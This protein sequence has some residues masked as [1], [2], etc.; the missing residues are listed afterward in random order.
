MPGPVPTPASRE[1]KPMARYKSSRV[2]ADKA[3]PFSSML[4]ASEATGIR[5]GMRP[6]AAFNNVVLPLPAAPLT[7][8]RCPSSKLSRTSA[9]TWS[10]PPKP[11][12]R[13]ESLSMRKL[14]LAVRSESLEAGRM[15][16]LENLQGRN[17]QKRRTDDHR[18]NIG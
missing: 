3:L 17:H 8:S 5:R 11:T 18:D 6:A 10:G 9:S 2:I 14:D 1:A 12:L 7:I 13:F 16:A 4:P 15:S